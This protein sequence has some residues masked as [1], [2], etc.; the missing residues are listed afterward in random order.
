MNDQ[1]SPPPRGPRPPVFK[2]P[3]GAGKS[4]SGVRVMAAPGA[5]PPAPGSIVRVLIA[6]RGW[7]VFCA[8]GVSIAGIG[9][10]LYARS[11]WRTARLVERLSVEEYSTMDRALLYLNI[12]FA[13]AFAAGCFYV[14]P[15]LF[16]YAGAITRLRLA[17]RMHELESALRHQR[18]VWVVFGSL[19]ALWLVLFVFQ[20]ASVLIDLTEQDESA[21]SVEEL[22]MYEP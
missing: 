12:V 17:S 10:A 8:F 13:A 15:R 2:P 9:A 14:V 21:D 7:T 18:A 20:M 19:A 3:A 16:R 11:Q 5:S 4:G 1:P 22:E 6:T